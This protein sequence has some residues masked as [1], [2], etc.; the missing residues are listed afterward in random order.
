MRTNGQFI[1][2]QNSNFETH[3][4]EPDQKL[5]WTEHA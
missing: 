1:P 4:E 5:A 3:A 2:E